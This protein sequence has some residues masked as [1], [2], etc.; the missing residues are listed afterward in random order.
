LRP[1][2][3]A[4]DLTDRNLTQKTRCIHSVVGQNKFVK[5]WHNALLLL[6]C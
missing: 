2:L 4:Y 3:V 1:L 6:L 5:Q